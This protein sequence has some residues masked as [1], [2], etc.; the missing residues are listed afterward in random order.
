MNKVSLAWK[1]V[2]G[3]KITVALL[4]GIAAYLHQR[5]TTKAGV[6]AWGGIAGITSVAALA[7]GVFLA[8]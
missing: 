8:G 2:V 5:A 6:A 3:I 1:V 7:L 4:A